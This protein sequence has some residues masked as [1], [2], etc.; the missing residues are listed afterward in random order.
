[1]LTVIS[2]N[3][4]TFLELKHLFSV[5]LIHE[6]TWKAVTC[7]SR[8]QRG[9]K[10]LRN[11]SLKASFGNNHRNSYSISCNVKRISTVRLNQLCCNNIEVSKLLKR[12]S[13]YSRQAVMPHFSGHTRQR[14]IDSGLSAVVVESI[15]LPFQKKYF[16]L[17]SNQ[18]GRNCSFITY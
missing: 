18:L 14:G 10:Y 3:T 13:Y 16:C 8:L 11:C 17:L 4:N 1:M 12:Q 7:K 2:A 6:D 5:S 9:M 15:A